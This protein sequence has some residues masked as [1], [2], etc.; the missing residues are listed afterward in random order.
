M[1][2]RYW[3]AVKAFFDRRHGLANMLP[4]PCADGEEDLDA[5]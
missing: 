2:G 3:P 4:P 1:G 5:L